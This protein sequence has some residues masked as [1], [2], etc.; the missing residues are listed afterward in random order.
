MRWQTITVPNVGTNNG[1]TGAQTYTYDSLN[2]LQ[3]AEEKIAGATSWKQTFTYDR[4][5]NKNFDAANTTTLGSCTTAICNPTFP[6]NSTNIN[7]FTDGQGYS[8]DADGSVTQDAAGQR[9]GYDAEGRQNAFFATGN[10]TGTPTL[11]YAFDGEGKRVKTFVGSS[12]TIFVYDAGGE[13]V[14]EYDNSPPMEEEH[15]VSYMTNDHLGSPRIVTDANGAVVSRKDFAAFGDETLTSQRTTALGYN[16]PEVRQDYTGYLKDAESGLE[17]AQAR[18]YNPQHGRFTSVDPLTASGTIKNPQTFNRYAYALNSPYKFADPLG[19][20]GEVCGAENSNCNGSGGSGNS[21][22][23]EAQAAYDGRFQEMVQAVRLQKQAQDAS[24][25]G[26][27]DAMWD[28]IDNSNGLIGAKFAE[29]ANS[30]FS[31]GS[32]QG[33]DFQNTAGSSTPSGFSLIQKYILHVF[34]AGHLTGANNELRILRTDTALIN[35]LELMSLKIFRF[36]R[37]FQTWTLEQLAN[38]EVDSTMFNAFLKTFRAQARLTIENEA[39]KFAYK[40]GGTASILV[41]EIATG[42]AFR[43]TL[44]MN[45]LNQAARSIFNMSWNMGIVTAPQPRRR[46]RKLV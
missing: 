1:F 16:V 7:R 34:G 25:R 17:Y 35:A 18:Y 11:N 24:N 9:F 46:S 27:Y 19:L 4:F 3:I 10:S 13:L 44:E 42:H 45:N 20:M 6:T 5:G 41:R 2:R 21:N 33:Q 28:I 32:I 43:A 31:A 26:D 30:L 38:P 15:R 29:G 37:Q 23:D 14:A 39:T 8:Y 36:A 22:I 12:A 40:F